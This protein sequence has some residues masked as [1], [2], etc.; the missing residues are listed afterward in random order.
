MTFLRPK[1]LGP[2]LFVD[3]F[4]D[5][6]YN[7]DI[8]DYQRD[9]RR[10]YLIAYHLVW[11]PSRRK[12]VLV[13]RIAKD[14]DRIIRGKCAEMGWQV[15]ELEIQPDHIHLFVRAWPSTSAYEIIRACKDITSNNLRL[16]Y[17]V[18]RRLPSLWTRSY[19][20]STAENVSKETIRKYVEAQKR[21]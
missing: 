6:Y 1:P 12:K 20:A 15:L 11:C 19:F 17:P 14:C 8:M 3:I 7:I 16:K 21:T 2:D 5:Q 9:E 4:V 10:V 18:L 13:G